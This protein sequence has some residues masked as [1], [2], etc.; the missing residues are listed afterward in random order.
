MQMNRPPKNDGDFQPCPQGM[1]QV[2]LVDIVDCGWQEQFHEGRS[3]G[4]Q[5]FVKLVWASSHMREDGLPFCVF[6]RRMKWSF[7]EK[8]A[9]YDRLTTW[10]GRA[11]IEQMLDSGA[12]MESLL[13]QNAF[14]NVEHNSI[15]GKTYANVGAIAPL[16]PGMMPISYP[17][18]ERMECR[19]SW[20]D[21]VPSAFTDKAVALRM[22]GERAG[23]ATLPTDGQPPQQPQQSA[24]PPAPQAPPP[25]A[26]PP[27]VNTTP[28]PVNNPVAPAPPPP[29]APVAP[30]YEPM[31]PEQ[32][33]E[34]VNMGQRLWG[35]TFH[36]ELE[37]RTQKLFAKSWAMLNTDECSRLLFELRSV[38]PNI[39]EPQPA[40]PV[41]NA[42]DESVYMSEPYNPFA[43]EGE[44]GWRPDGHRDVLEDDAKNKARAAQVQ[45]S[46][47]QPQLVPEPAAAGYSPT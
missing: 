24:P 8:S 7:H 47:Q 29:A 1:Q 2:V 30:A 11:Y 10:L 25:A 16:V 33:T 26:A 23:Q 45:Q 4:F 6:D 32:M 12:S 31:K 46:Q 18:F 35:A 9:L 40:Q 19:E 43:D 13:G 20:I 28:M 37:T 42:Y 5:P 38:K 3:K 36:Q 44:P 17:D 15:E 34:L 21:P 41:Q 27:V 14:I 39:V 22:L